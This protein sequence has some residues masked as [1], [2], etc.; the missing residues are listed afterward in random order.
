QLRTRIIT[1]K[2]LGFHQPAE[3]IVEYTNAGD[4]AMPA[5]LLV[6]AAAQAG[7]E[8]ALMS[9][10]E[11]QLPRGFWT[12]AIPDGFSNAVQFLAGGANPGVW[13]PGEVGRVT[14]YYAGWEK[15]WDRDEPFDFRVGS[16]TTDNGTAIGWDELK[17]LLR[18]TL[19]TPAA[20]GPIFENLVA[21][22]GT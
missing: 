8:G 2:A 6:V 17:P 19:Y 20:W 12:S 1:P 21:A 9:L 4:V 14:I 16:V 10:D 13:Q 22:V 7:R 3:I 5:P 11:R 18:P 15:P